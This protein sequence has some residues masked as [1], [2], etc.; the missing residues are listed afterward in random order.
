MTAAHPDPHGRQ[1]QLIST[2]LQ[3]EERNSQDDSVYGYSR[4]FKDVG[5]FWDF[6]SLHQKDANGQRTPLEWK[7]F[8][9]ALSQMGRSEGFLSWDIAYKAHGME[10]RFHPTLFVS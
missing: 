10:F 3:K 9:E 5:L 1:L 8:G 2:R 7:I 4:Y 6:G